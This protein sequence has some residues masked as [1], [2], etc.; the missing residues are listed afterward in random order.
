MKAWLDHDAVLTVDVGTGWMSRYEFE[1][2]SVGCVARS[3]TEAGTASRVLLNGSFFAL[4]SVRVSEASGDQGGPV[5]C[6]SLDSFEE[7]GSTACQP[8]R[9]DDAGSL[10]PFSV[11]VGSVA[12]RLR[13]L[14]GAGLRTIVNLGRPCPGGAEADAELV[15]AGVPVAEGKVSVIGENLGI[16]VTR[17]RCELPSGAFPRTTGAL[18]APGYRG[19]PV[20]DYNFRMPD[21]FTKRAIMRFEAL[22]SDFL[23]ALQARFPEF[24][25][26]R[27][28]VVDQL[29]Y[30]EWLDD[31]LRPTG[32]VV[33]FTG[34]E[35]V[36]AYEREASPALPA[37]GIVE[38]PDEA[39][40]LSEQAVAGLREWAASRAGMRESIP[41]QI[42]FDSATA[43]MLER[44]SGFAEGLACL[45]SGWLGVADLRV[46]RA[47]GSADAVVSADPVLRSGHDRWGMILIARLESPEGGRMD[48][49]YPEGRIDPFL[50]L[51]G[52]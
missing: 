8:A 7:P 11:R 51:L 24:S 28:A 25:G 31:P 42:A 36:R 9:G 47:S 14:E 15:V 26:W 41:Y 35:L 12:L 13:S 43:R 46:G 6:V 44:D 39:R 3:G 1:Q 22:H 16:R 45:R 30:G 2:L 37:T 23:R 34:A 5:F 20:K 50:P 27:I 29:T 32:A 4:G 18:L 49:V 38:A 19:E 52:R 10:L 48:I 21:R 40:P 17:L 33:R